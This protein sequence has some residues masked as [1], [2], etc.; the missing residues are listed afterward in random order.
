MHATIIAVAFSITTNFVL[1]KLWTFEDRD[2]A[3]GKTLFQ[4]GLFAGFSAFGALIQLSLLYFL[5]ENSH[6]D[7]ILG[8]ILAVAVAS[9]GNFILNKK[10]TFKEKIWG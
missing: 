7:R 9:I 5:V 3:L 2:F 1:N 8:G 4:F 10:W 6:M